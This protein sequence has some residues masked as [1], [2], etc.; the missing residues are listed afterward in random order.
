MIKDVIKRARAKRAVIMVQQQ[1]VHFLYFYS[2][3]R[4]LKVKTLSR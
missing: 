1:S 4:F 2:I 3:G